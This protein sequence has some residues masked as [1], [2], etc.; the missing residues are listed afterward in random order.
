MV[1]KDNLIKIFTGTEIAVLA[2]KSKLEEAGISSV[3]RND[4]QHG[5]DIGIIAGVRS[6][7]DLYILESDLKRADPVISSFTDEK[8][9]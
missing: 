8:N 9:I 2:L 1:D 6:A 7:V 5:V 3:V 4:Y